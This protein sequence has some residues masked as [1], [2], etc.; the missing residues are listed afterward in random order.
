MIPIHKSGDPTSPHNYRPI[1]ILEL[2]TMVS[3][4]VIHKRINYYQQFC[5][6]LD[7]SGSWQDSKVRS[8]IVHVPHVILLDHKILYSNIFI[9]SFLQW[10]ATYVK[11]GTAEILQTQAMN[12]V[13]NYFR[14]F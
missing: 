9:S 7:F 6:A 5:K 11:H 12:F 3:E 13:I 8:G 2:F 14:L 1:S 4:K 10:S